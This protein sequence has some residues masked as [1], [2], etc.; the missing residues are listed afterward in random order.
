MANK[1][2]IAAALSLVVFLI[3]SST[4]ACGANISEFLKISDLSVNDW[5]SED[6]KKNL[7]EIEKSCRAV[8][9][10]LNKNNKEFYGEDCISN[11]FIAATFIHNTNQYY[12]SLTP[13]DG[14]ANKKI[15]EISE[16]FRKVLNDVIDKAVSEGKAGTEKENINLIYTV[17]VTVQKDIVAD[18]Y[19][20]VFSDPE[21]AKSSF[22]IAGAEDGKRI[23]REGEYKQLYKEIEAKQ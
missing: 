10:Y 11:L 21:E 23:Y 2:L 7:Y 13:P 20:N 18:Y 4:P 15:R 17:I 22:L 16:K 19:H 3:I 14:V 5:I 9:S 1:K 12:Q 8:E 6:P